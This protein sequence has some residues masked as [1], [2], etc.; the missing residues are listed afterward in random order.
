MMMKNLLKRIA[1]AYF[2]QLEA[3]PHIVTYMV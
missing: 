1:G 3:N 2:A